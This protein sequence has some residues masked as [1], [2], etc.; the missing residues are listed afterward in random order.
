MVLGTA[1]SVV[2]YYPAGHW[3]VG[4]QAYT[5]SIAHCMDSHRS[6]NQTSPI[7]LDL[8]PT[9]SM[10]KSMVLAGVECEG[11]RRLGA[12]CSVRVCVTVC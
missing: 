2:I 1:V 9:C 5:R 12:L 4:R 11:G 7:S 3:V 10:R 8:L 6:Q